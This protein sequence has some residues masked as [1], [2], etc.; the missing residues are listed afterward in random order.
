MN[1]RPKLRTISDQRV[2]AF[3][4]SPK[5]GHIH[6]GLTSLISASSVRE[7]SSATNSEESPDRCSSVKTRSMI[8]LFQSGYRWTP[9]SITGLHIASQ[10]G[11]GKSSRPS[12]IPVVAVCPCSTVPPASREEV[13]GED[14]RSLLCFSRDAAQTSAP[15]V[16]SKQ[17]SRL[18]AYSSTELH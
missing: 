17:E 11:S 15:S 8:S 2:S 12:R 14:V 16:H 9:K 10:Y 13:T 3:V 1:S 4:P 7:A 6:H 18:T 5:S